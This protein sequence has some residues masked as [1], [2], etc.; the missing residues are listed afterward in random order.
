MTSTLNIR[1]IDCASDDAR[2]AIRGPSASPQ[3]Q[4]RRRQPTGPGADDRGV[5]R[6]R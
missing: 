2:E 3:P 6:A 1:R 4:G 5:R